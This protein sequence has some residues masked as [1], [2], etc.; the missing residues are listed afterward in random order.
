MKTY[1]SVFAAAGATLAAA[2]AAHAL[3]TGVDLAF[4]PAW[5]S[6]AVALLL[7]ALALVAFGLGRVEDQPEPASSGSPLP[8][9]LET[10]MRRRP[11]QTAAALV[12]VGALVARNPR[13]VAAVMA[14]TAAQQR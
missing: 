11:A 10:A 12:A 6:L 7:A 1:L 14:E 2:F 5:A 4:G 3:W 13:A 9:L 8:A